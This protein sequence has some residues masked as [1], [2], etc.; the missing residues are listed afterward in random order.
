[1][2]RIFWT[3][4]LALTTC[5]MALMQHV[6]LAQDVALAQ[7]EKKVELGQKAPDFTA[8]GIDEVSFQLSDRVGKGKNVVLM[9]SRANW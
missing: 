7:E 9:F 4:T 3:V 2:R 6:A 8:I 1:M 5:P